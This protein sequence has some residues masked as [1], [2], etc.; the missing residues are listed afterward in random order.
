VTKEQREKNR[1][2]KLRKKW[3][4]PNRVCPACGGK[5]LSFGSICDMREYHEG[6][7]IAGAS[8]IPILPITCTNCGYTF[9]FNAIKLGILDGTGK[10]LFE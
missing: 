5:I 4:E 9:M 3:P 10:E 7:Y 6:Y 1:V 8:A 2:E